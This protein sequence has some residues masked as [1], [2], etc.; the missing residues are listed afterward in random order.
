MCGA[1]PPTRLYGTEGDNY[2]CFT[3]TY[4]HKIE[5]CLTKYICLRHVS[6]LSLGWLFEKGF[7]LSKFALV[8]HKS[9]TSCSHDNRTLVIYITSYTNML[10]DI[11]YVDAG[12][13]L[14]KKVQLSNLKVHHR[15]Q[16]SQSLYHTSSWIPT[17][18]C[19]STCPKSN[20]H[21]PYASVQLLSS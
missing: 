1:V 14:F 6:W 15:H 12:F 7:Q 9:M 8:P 13:R 10:N 11:P 17:S 19:Q 16:K 20:S 4:K 3:F 5:I 21:D 18:S 2:N